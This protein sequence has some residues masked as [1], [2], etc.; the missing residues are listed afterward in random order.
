VLT[1]T[2][3]ELFTRVI[4][5]EWIFFGVLALGLI[6]L[7]VSNSRTPEYRMIGYPITPVLFALAAFAIVINHIVSDPLG[8]LSGLG[9][10]AAGLPVF[11]FWT[12]LSSS[13][14]SS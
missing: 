8:S 12:S 6:K 1:A 4:Y 10:V 13:A 14:R 2:Y 9:V 7:R 11:I 3:R 5:T